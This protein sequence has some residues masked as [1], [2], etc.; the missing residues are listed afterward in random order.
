MNIPTTDQAGHVQVGI[1]G[2]ALLGG[3]QDFNATAA[4]NEQQRKNH[5]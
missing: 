1:S 3:A 4:N 5:T 2:N